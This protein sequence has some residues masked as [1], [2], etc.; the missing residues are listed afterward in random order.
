MNDFM[1]FYSISVPLMSRVAPSDTYKVYKS[2]SRVRIDTTL[3][4]FDN[5]SWKRGNRSY[6]FTG[7]KD[8]AT[9]IE[10]D[11]DL[12]EY[13]IEQLR[14]VDEDIHGIAPSKESIQF[15]LSSP[16]VN[17]AV[18]FEN[19]SFERNKS[20]LWGWMRSGDKTESI[21]GYECK[22]FSADNINFV[23]RTRMDHLDEESSRARN[24]RTPLGFVLGIS[25]NPSPTTEEQNLAPPSP[26]HQTEQPVKAEEYFTDTD[27]GERDVGRPKKITTKVQKFKAN[28]WLSDTFPINLQSQVLPILNLMSN[29]ASPHV[30]KL[31]DF[32]TM[33]L[34]AGFPVKIEIPLFHLINAVVTFSNC[35]TLDN[36]VA[37]VTKVE[38]N[39][40]VTVTIEDNVF[41]IPT[42]YARSGPDYRQ[43]NYDDDDELMQIAIQQ[44]LL[45]SGTETEEVN[46]WE[47]LRSPSISPGGYDDQLQ[48]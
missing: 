21:N 25:D 40:R 17:T 14:G 10:I 31:K 39:D 5:T 48:R 47:A 26:I 41:E 44:S 2:G 27:L 18:D 34:P 42:H 15:R 33:Q 1:T 23:T 9:F 36:P 24:S 28:L 12:E 11:R 6:I 19:I 37:Q 13:S 35:M 7:D 43:I 32:I 8:C 3:L 46:L 4:G 22:V 45:E 16:V 30:N 20:G 29:V 38:E